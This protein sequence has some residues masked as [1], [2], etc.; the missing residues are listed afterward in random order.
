[1]L[2]GLCGTRNAGKNTVSQY[3]VNELGFTQLLD[4]VPLQNFLV[5]AHVETVDSAKLKTTSHPSPE[6]LS[7]CWRSNINIVID[8]ID[9]FDPILPDLL[10]RPYFALVFIDAPFGLRFRR[11]VKSDLSGN[12]MEFI[13]L[14]DKLRRTTRRTVQPYNSNVHNPVLRSKP[15][16]QQ[17]LSLVEMQHVSRVQIFNEC[18]SDEQL[19]EAMRAIQFTNPDLLRPSWDTYFLSLAKLASQRTNCMKRRVGCVITK[20]K[21]VVATGYNGTPSGVTNCMDG[22]CPRCNASKNSQGVDLDLCLCLH[23][24]E[25]A[26]IEAGRNRCNGGALYTNLFPCILCSKKIVQSGI[27]RVV[28]ETHYCTDTPSEKLLRAGGVVVEQHD[29]GKKMPPLVYIV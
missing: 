22:G 15:I 1:M 6:L 10:K 23:A 2:I 9:P 18:E 29:G 24:E 13:A 5:S 3:L 14:D 25:N 28:F 20:D 21:R 27:A 4:T 16:A 12:V 17:G 7:Q 8:C 19:Y 26:I 11:A